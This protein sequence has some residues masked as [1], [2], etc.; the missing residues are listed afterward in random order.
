MGGKSAKHEEI[1]DLLNKA[2][3]SLKSVKDWTNAGNAFAEA[4]TYYLKTPFNRHEAAPCYL[5]AAQCFVKED[6]LAAVDA[7]QRA[8]EIFKGD[9]KSVAKYQKEIAQIY[10]T[11]E[12]F[13]NA[14]KYFESAAELFAQEGSPF[15]ANT[16]FLKVAHL[17]TLYQSVD[18]AVFTFEKI[19]QSAATTTWMSRETFVKVGLCHLSTGDRVAVKKVVEKWGKILPHLVGSREYLFLLDIVAMYDNFDHEGFQT[20]VR[21]NEA[22]LEDTWKQNLIGKISDQIKEGEVDKR[23]VMR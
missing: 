2:A 17:A 19:L 10:E 8:I 5:K 13:Q 14:M 4:A 16:C 18:K 22:I 11:R 21:Y 9:G 12:D 1:A 23:M 6:P 20:V 15:L 7:Y 3:N